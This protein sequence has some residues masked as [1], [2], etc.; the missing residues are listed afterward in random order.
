MLSYLS[1]SVKDQNDAIHSRTSSAFTQSHV[2]RSKVQTITIS[3]SQQT[4]LEKVCYSLVVFIFVHVVEVEHVRLELQ[5]ISEH[6]TKA[7]IIRSRARWYEHSDRKSKYFMNLEKC[8]YKRKHI[9]KLK[10]KE[11]GHLEEPNKILSHMKN[12]Y[13]TLY[14]SQT[15][16]DTFNASALHFLN[17]NNIKGLHGEHQKICERLSM[18]K[19]A[20]LR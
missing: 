17:C 15:S 14:S 20:Y 2:T 5:K 19:N 13:K 12:F 8:A 4:S 7:A 6:K 3:T 16:E 9:V 10:T 1:A 11:N 18:K